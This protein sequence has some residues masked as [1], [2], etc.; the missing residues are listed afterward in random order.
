MGNGPQP[1]MGH[2]ASMSVPSGRP[3]FPGR[4]HRM[5]CMNAHVS[6]SIRGTTPTATPSAV[7]PSRYA[8]GFVA[9]F[10][11]CSGP[12]TKPMGKFGRT[13]MVTAVLY[14]V[15]LMHILYSIL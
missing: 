15:Y 3:G 10:G 1:N 2:T 13:S 9:Q 14:E 11:L 4:Q 6:A 7:T 12:H 5:A 8:R